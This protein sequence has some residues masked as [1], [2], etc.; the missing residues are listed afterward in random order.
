MLNMNNKKNIIITGVTG[1]DG[2]FLCS[3]LLTENNLDFIYGF[4]RDTEN[5]EFFKRINYLNKE[6]DV[7]KIR[8]IDSK[9]LLHQNLYSLFN[10]I[11]PDYIF[12]MSGPSSVYES[13]ENP[14]NAKKIEDIFLNLISAC[15]KN[16]L[17]P[18]FFQASSSEMFGKVKENLLNENT[19][20]NPNSPYA[21]SKL[22]VHNK[23]KELR[24]EHEWPIVSGIMFNHESEFRDENYLFMKIINY[25]IKTKKN[26]VDGPLSLGSLKFRR[27]WSYAKDISEAVIMMMRSENNKDY[28][29]GSGK[30]HSIQDIVEI[31]FGIFDLNWRKY[32]NIE[33]ELLRKNDPQEVVSDPSQ[34]KNDLGWSTTTSIE[35]IVEKIIKFKNI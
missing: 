25:V 32:I 20:F 13:L 15:L 6:I 16:N 24:I 3:Q 2:L 19:S 28:V 33:K 12:N 29:L 34:I 22:N 11:K 14:Q 35:A 23:V 17:K 26:E 31:I 27:D 21:L 10:E 8:L 7:K 30:S 5:K 4:T 1:Q 18:N 9:Y